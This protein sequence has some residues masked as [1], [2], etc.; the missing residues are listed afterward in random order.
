MKELSLSEMRRMQAQ[1]H[2]KYR[3]SWRPQIPENGHYN[4]L[5]M[6][7]E[8]GEAIS[9]IK[10]FGDDAVMNDG[11]LRKAFISELCDIWMFMEDVMTCYGVTPEEFSAV[12]AEKHAHNMSRDYDK[13]CEQIYEEYQ[14]KFTKGEDAHAPES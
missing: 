9:V 3:D 7:E 8:L 6:V 1:L 2:E 4:L 11:T 10:K 5:W 13:N 12:Y 14:D